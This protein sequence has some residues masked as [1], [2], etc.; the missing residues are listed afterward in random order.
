MVHLDLAVKAKKRYSSDAA[1]NLCIQ[2]YNGR[3]GSIR[4]CNQQLSHSSSRQEMVL[5]ASNSCIGHRYGECLEV[6]SSLL[7]GQPTTTNGTA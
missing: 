6:A 3:S 7:Q 5:G 1:R 4:Q 2:S